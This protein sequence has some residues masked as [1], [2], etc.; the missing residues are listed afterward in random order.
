MR[1][2][3]Q[4]CLDFLVEDKQ[5]RLTTCPSFS[6][7]NVFITPDGRKAATSSGC[8]MDIALITDIFASCVEAARL[9]RMDHDFV[10]SIQHA[11]EKLVQYKVGKHGQ[12]QEW[13]EDFDEAEPGHRHMS[14]MYGLYPGREITLRKTPD[15]AKAARVSLERRLK[16]GGAYTGWSR[17]WAINFWA[18]LE[19]GER[20]NE[21]LQMLMLH[22]T[23]PNL[24]DTHPA[25][26]GWIFQID[27]N[28]GATAAMAE[29]LLQSHDGAIHFLPALPQAWHEGRV[30]GLRARGGIEASIVWAKGRAVEAT[31]SASAPGE[32]SLRPPAGQ[33]IS[34]VS[35]GK[36]ALAGKTDKDGVVRVTFQRGGSY[37]IQ[38]A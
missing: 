7:E 11:K 5:G 23:G 36:Q 22:S 13:S 12:L 37:R 35:S 17:A 14:H 3:A 30:K 32:H 33:Q 27:G 8:A 2:A 19:D 15:L 25:G 29:M 9:L 18:R 31:L 6:T 1:G 21:S 38:F 16:A 24:F 26:Q 20:A 4:F 10:A 34:S 28:F